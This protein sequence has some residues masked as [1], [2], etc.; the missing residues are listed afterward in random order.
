MEE[1]VKTP[2]VKVIINIAESAEEKD[3]KFIYPQ[4]CSYESA[5]RSTIGAY[6]HL[7]RLEFE[8]FRIAE[9]KKQEE[10]KAKEVTPEL[11]LPEMN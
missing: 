2:D 3:F 9:A 11:V 7:V 10:E 8:A 4:G 5:K 6:E 1:Q